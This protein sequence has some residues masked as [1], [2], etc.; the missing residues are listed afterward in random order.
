MIGKRRY[1]KE[2]LTDAVQNARSMADVLRH[3]GL[4]LTGGNYR[5]I[6]S[7]VRHFGLSTAH[8]TGKLWSKG[9][10]AAQDARI[11]A[12]AKRISLPDDQVFV[13]NARPIKGISLRSRLVRLGWQ[14]Q[15]A[16][17]SLSEWRNRPLTLHVDHKNGIGNDNR[18]CN[19]RFLCP[20]CHQQ[21]PTW[22]HKGRNVADS[23]DA[24]D[25]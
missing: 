5:H 13:E 24:Q 23:L 14:Y 16:I 20:N 22:G 7:L 2:L 11:R 21:T 17:C 10:T 8:F 4:K 1:T 9:K 15:C 19:L 25:A 12:Q 3:F 6:S 18:L